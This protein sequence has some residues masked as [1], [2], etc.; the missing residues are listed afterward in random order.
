MDYLLLVALTV[1]TLGMILLVGYYGILVRVILPAL[2]HSLDARAAGVTLAAVERRALPLIILAIAL[3]VATGLYLLVVDEHYEGLGNF[4]ASSWTALMGVK[5][6][7]VFGMV[8][9]GVALDRL[10]AMVPDPPDDAA[11]E[12]AMGLVELAAEG[13]TGLGALVVLLTV[14][15]QLS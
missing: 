7:V 13:M 9:L 3:F 6:L 8:L 11:R 12:R 15:A 4:T 5:H 2:R 10:I 14:A 1:H